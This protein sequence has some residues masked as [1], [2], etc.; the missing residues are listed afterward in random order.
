MRSLYE[1][2]TVGLRGREDEWDHAAKHADVHPK[3]VKRIVDGE[4]GNPGV[5]TMESLADWLRLNPRRVPRAVR[6]PSQ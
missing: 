5:K 2:V 4:V 3:T 6:Q 1:Y